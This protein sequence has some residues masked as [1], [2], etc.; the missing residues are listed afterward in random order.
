MIKVCFI[1][2]G[3]MC[4]SPMAEFLFKALIKEKGLEKSFKIISRAT[5]REA[6]GADMSRYCKE[7][8]DRNE[9]PYT[10]HTA[11]QINLDVLKNMDYVLYMDSRNEDYLKN[12]FNISELK[13]ACRLSYFHNNED[14]EDPYFTGRY[15]YVFNKIKEE[16][17]FFFDYLI[18]QGK[19]KL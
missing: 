14:I 13:N 6:L 16:I 11:K 12:M 5:S 17:N 15:N 1:C 19:V 4:R 18:K 8:F 10:K 3:N 7:I 2:H 9:I